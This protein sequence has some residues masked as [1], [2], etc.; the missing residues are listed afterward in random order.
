[1]P[2]PTACAVASVSAQLPPCIDGL[3]TDTLQHNQLVLCSPPPD[4]LPEVDILRISD[5][6]LL[7]YLCRSRAIFPYFC[8]DNDTFLVECLTSLRKVVFPYPYKQE[9]LI[10]RRF[11]ADDATPLSVLRMAL[12]RDSLMGADRERLKDACTRPH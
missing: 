9:Y 2:F 6:L 11:D 12:V 5:P 1:M 3:I 10:A 8:N 4:C 7:D